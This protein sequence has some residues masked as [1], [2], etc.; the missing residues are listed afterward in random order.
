[1]GSR[2]PGSRTRGTHSSGSISSPTRSREPAAPL[3][4]RSFLHGD[5]SSPCRG[6]VGVELNTGDPII[7][8]ASVSVE[9]G[10]IVG[11]V[12]ESG[13]GKTT[14]AL[15]SPRLRAPG[16]PH[17]HG[18]IR[19]DGQELLGLT[20]REL[21]PL[22]GR[23]VSYVPQDPAASLNPG[24]Q[25]AISSGRPSGRIFLRKPQIRKRDACLSESISQVAGTFG[26]ISLTNSL[27]GNSS[28]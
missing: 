27:A 28:G 16:G 25:S 2:S 18:S 17:T 19:I 13:S 8:E 4:Q 12:G 20:D 21:R 24:L 11:I 26:A 10:A 7:H 1:M 15:C 14:L 22:R 5:F 6:G 3:S 9:S 23:L